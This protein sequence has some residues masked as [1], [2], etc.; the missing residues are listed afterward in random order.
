MIKVYSKKSILLGLILGFIGAGSSIYLYLM[1]E[2]PFYVLGLFITGFIGWIWFGT[3]YKI[4]G[5]ELIVVAGPNRWK[6]DLKLLRK[7]SK[8]Q[9]FISAPANSFDRFLL[10]FENKSELIISPNST[11]LFDHIKK[12]FKTVQFDN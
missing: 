9:S 10:K 2:E 11:L 8:T 12:N 3:Y 6:K 7:V 4:N 5:D 1:I